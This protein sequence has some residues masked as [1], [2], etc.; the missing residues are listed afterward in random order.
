MLGWYLLEWRTAAAREA[1]NAVLGNCRNGDT[2]EK[3]VLGARGWAGLVTMAWPLELPVTP[4]AAAAAAGVQSLQ[5]L[6]MVIALPRG[7]TTTWQYD[8]AAAA[9]ATAAV[10]AAKAAGSSKGKRG[11]KKSPSKGSKGGGGSGASNR[12]IGS[13]QQQQREWFVT[14]YGAA[15]QLHQGA[16][17]VGPAHFMATSW[18]ALWPVFLRAAVQRSD[19]LDAQVCEHVYACVIEP[20]CMPILFQPTRSVARRPDRV[21]SIPHC[22]A[23]APCPLAVRS[24]HT[25]SRT[26]VEAHSTIW[27]LCQRT[28]VL[29]AVTAHPACHRPSRVL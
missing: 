8:P 3:E 19:A 27:L 17:L 25:G 11:K 6:S 29:F 12:G 23:V 24:C 18:A 21:A 1:A 20:I 14:P 22:L 26:H 13:T 7:T 15:W 10:A 2:A 5:K 4:A 28:F 16:S 9:A